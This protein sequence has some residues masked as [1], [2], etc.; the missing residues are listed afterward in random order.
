MK[1]SADYN[2]DSSSNIEYRSKTG[3]YFKFCFDFGSMTQIQEY[4][5]TQQYFKTNESLVRLYIAITKS[6][7]SYA[8]IVDPNIGLEGFFKI[9]QLIVTKYK[10]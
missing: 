5:T 8:T 6:G 9:F 10:H 4:N 2:H 3:R 1:S 7:F